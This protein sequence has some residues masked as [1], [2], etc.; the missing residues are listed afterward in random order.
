MS[1]HLHIAL[2]TLDVLPR[3][4][5]PY[6]NLFARLFAK[7]LGDGSASFALH[8]VDMLPGDHPFFGRDAGAILDLKGTEEGPPDSADDVERREIQGRFVAGRKPRARVAVN[9]GRFGSYFP[10]TG[11]DEAMRTL[12]EDEIERWDLIVF[13]GS[14]LCCTDA[15]E[16][17]EILEVAREVIA[18]TCEDAPPSPLKGA[19]VL[20]ICFG[21]QLL[22]EAIAE[23]P[24]GARHV[25]RP[26]PLGGFQEMSL[27]GARR[28]R[29][30][31]DAR[32]DDTNPLSAHG[33]MPLIFYVHGDYV[34]LSAAD[35]DGV[36][37]AKPGFAG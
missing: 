16:A 12:R 34:P 28:R 11:R 8:N 25:V 37:R 33:D 21:F 31:H 17:G 5:P 14:R 4:S 6:W 10:A 32:E 2:V 36:L 26:N 7:T 35:E 1:R 27:R 30:F 22:A 3:G 19:R 20:G 24:S 18:A 23:A 9:R 13:P 29:S 15:S